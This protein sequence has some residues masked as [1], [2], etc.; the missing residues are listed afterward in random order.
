MGTMFLAVYRSASHAVCFLTIAEEDLWADKSR[1]QK[2][3]ISR[4]MRICHL[5]WYTFLFPRIQKS[6]L[7]PI[8]CFVLSQCEIVFHELVFLTP[9]PP[10]PP[11]T[12]CSQLIEITSTDYFSVVAGFVMV[13]AVLG[14]VLLFL[15]FLLSLFVCV[16]FV[17]LLFFV[18]VFGVFF[19]FVVVVFVWGFLMWFLCVF[20]FFCECFCW[21]S[22]LLVVINFIYLLFFVFEPYIRVDITVDNV[23]S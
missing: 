3:T 18:S 14:G 15:L 4:V 17:W 8:W 16:L 9:S 19:C 2:R 7:R 13:V 6:K 10:P 20:W 1:Q 21:F 11:P 5:Y 22:F 23:S 12:I